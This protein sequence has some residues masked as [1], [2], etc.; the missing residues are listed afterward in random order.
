[1]MLG[2]SL[3]TWSRHDLRMLSTL[4]TN[5]S[6]FMFFDCVSEPASMAGRIVTILGYFICCS[7]FLEGMFLSRT[8][9]F[10]RTAVTVSGGATIITVLIYYARL[11]GCFLMKISGL[12]SLAAL[13]ASSASLT[14]HV[15]V[16]S[17]KC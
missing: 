15:E 2:L 3:K 1:M 9:P 16:S 8:R 17:P 14:S 10:T 5:S 4:F 13:Q 7:R 6:N 11:K 12:D